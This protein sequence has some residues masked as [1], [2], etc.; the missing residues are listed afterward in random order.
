MKH[1]AKN[2]ITSVTASYQ[3]GNFP[4]DNLLDDHPGR[5]WSAGGVVRNADLT[6]SIT[7]GCSDIAFFGTDAREATFSAYDPSEISWGADSWG[8]DSWGNSGV[9]ASG[10]VDVFDRS[11]A[12]WI[13]LT[14]P[15]TVPCIVSVNLTSS[16]SETLY[17]GIATGGLAEVYGGARIRYGAQRNRTDNAVESYNPLGYRYYKKTTLPKVLPVTARM[18]ISEY[19]KLDAYIEENGRIPSAWNLVEGYEGW[20]IFGFPDVSATFDYLAHVNLSMTIN[21]VI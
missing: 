11:N 9:S 7:E 13:T 4:A 12:L 2:C 21:E 19:N 16:G 20:L 3:D 18:E 6:L 14:T 15:I 10:T 1:I 17:A 8:E 5:I